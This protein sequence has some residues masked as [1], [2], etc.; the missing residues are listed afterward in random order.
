MS[1]MAGTCRAPDGTVHLWFCQTLGSFEADLVVCNGGEPGVGGWE[2]VDERVTCEA[3]KGEWSEE[4]CR[5][6]N[7]HDSNRLHLRQRVRK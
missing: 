1:L 6:R 7:K 5:E 3:C 2:Y 4:R